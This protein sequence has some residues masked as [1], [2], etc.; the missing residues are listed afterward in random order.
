MLIQGQAQGLAN[1]IFFFQ[2]YTTNQQKDLLYNHKL[3]KKKLTHL[4]NLLF[5][6]HTNQLQ[7]NITFGH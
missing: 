6:F 5:I 7:K 2:I 3:N 1:I 4:S